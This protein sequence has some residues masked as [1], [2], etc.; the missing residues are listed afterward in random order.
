MGFVRA[1][2]CIIVF[3][4]WVSDRA[5][6][7]AGHLREVAHRFLANLRVHTIH[8]KSLF[9]QYA[10]WF[11]QKA[12]GIWQPRVLDRGAT[13]ANQ[14]IKWQNILC[15]VIIPETCCGAGFP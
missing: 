15:H 1:N 11:Q 12:L 3:A 4:K 7:S 5:A 6:W 10:F 8:T 9:A 14:T 13:I 2:L